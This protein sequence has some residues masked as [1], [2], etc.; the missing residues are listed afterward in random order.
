MKKFQTT[1]KPT[2]KIGFAIAAASALFLTLSIWPWAQKMT[3]AAL[4]GNPTAAAAV[5]VQVAFTIAKKSTGC[6]TGLG[7]CNIKIGGSTAAA[8]KSGSSREVN[9]A[10]LVD[11]NGKLVCEF[12]DKLPEK[13]DRL[14]VEQSLQLSSDLAKKLG[15]KS[16]TIQQGDYSVSGG[17]ASVGAQLVK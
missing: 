4:N 12:S 6:S 10:L 13:G 14:A 3:G 7:I 11:D 1:F 9:G 17:R 16:A 5:R 8:A 15:L 2:F